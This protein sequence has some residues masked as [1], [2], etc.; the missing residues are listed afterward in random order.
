[1][2]ITRALAFVLLASSCSFDT[3]LP[4]APQL[5]RL[6]G[7][8][9]TQGHL[10]AEGQTVTLSSE[11]GDRTT[12]TT[13]ANGRFGFGDL[14]PGL[15]L[16]SAALPG[17]ARTSS[18]LLRVRAGQDTDA[19]VLRPDWLQNSPSE[20]T[21]SGKVTANGGGD[22][23]GAKIE[24]VLAGVAIAQV[25]VAGDGAFVQRL[26]PGT[27]TLR[28]SHPA[29]VTAML[30]DV[31][32][33]A[34][35]QRDL[36]A[37]PLVL[38]INPATLSGVVFRERDGQAPVA[39]AGATMTLDT[40]QTT[41]VDP[42]GNFT[43][44]GLAAGARQVR[45]TLVGHHDVLPT[46]PVV[47]EPGKTSTLEKVTL[48]IDRGQVVGVVKV[49][50]N[51][52]VSGARVELQGTNLAALVS[53]DPSDP[54][55]GGFV[56][57]NVPVGT[58][59]L[60]ARKDQYSNASAQ[61]V[62]SSDAPKDVGT[63][64]LARLLGDFAIDD[65]DSAN[66][67]GYTRTRAVTLNFTGFPSTGVA[68]FRA[69]EDPGF[70]G[71]TFQPYTGRLQPF[72]LQ[73]GEGAHTVYA[74]YQDTQGQTS[75][76]FTSAIVLDTIAPAAPMVQFDATGVAGTTRYTSR[77]QDLPLQ[78]VANDGM[79]S[80][81][82]L[83]RVGESVD[84]QGQV[85]R[86][87][88]T[89]KQ[90]ATLNRAAPV[91]GLQ[92]G[93]VQVIDHAGN[94]SAA[95]QAQVVVD[96]VAPSG[97]LAIRRGAKATDDGYT[98]QALVTLDETFVDG[99]GG[100]VLVKLANSSAELNT[101]VFQPA[102]TTASWL[103]NAANDG[104]KSVFAGFRDVAG[105]EAMS[106]AQASI[107]YDTQAPQ[108]ASATVV[109]AAIRNTA[110]VTLNLVTNPAD[111]SSTQALTV[112]D[113]P[114]FT[115]ASSTTPAAFPGTSQVAFVLSAGDGP[116]SIF[117]RYRDRAGNDAITSAQVTLDTVAP[118]GS[119]T[120]V[121]AL[122][123]GTP[124][125]TVTATTLV[126]VNLSPGDA[127]E[128][129]LGDGTM[130][131]CPAAGYTALVGTTI[132]NHPLPASGVVRVCLRDA[133]GNTRLLP[134]QTLVLDSAAP[135]SCA[136]VVRGFR[137]DGTDAPAGRSARPAILVSATGC[138]G[139]EVPREWV[140]TQS[141]VTCSAPGL[142]WQP[143]S[144]EQPYVLVGGDATHT[145]R[146][147][148]RDAARNP[149]S[150]AAAT[151]D[152]DTTA[153]SGVSVSIDTGAAY[154]NAAQYAARGNV[155][156]AQVAGSATGAT[157]WALSTTTTFGTYQAFPGTS[158]Q[159]FTFLGTGVQRVF[160]SF[161]DDLGNTAATVVDDI[162]FDVTAPSVAGSTVALVTAAPDPAFI[163]SSSVAARVAP[164]VPA[165]AAN[166]YLAQVSP[167][168]ACSAAAFGAGAPATAD[169]FFIANGG[170]G[171]KRLCVAYDDAAGNFSSPLTLDFTV[172]TTPPGQP[173][174][175]TPSQLTN[176]ADG[177]SFNVV[178][179]G[180]VVESNFLRYERATGLA[181]SW[182]TAS[183]TQS[184][185]SFAFTVASSAAVASTANVFKL[186]AVDRAGNTSPSSEVVVTTDVV[187]PAV[188]TL[189]QLGVQNFD[190]RGRV[191]WSQVS[192]AVSYRVHYGLNLLP[193]DG[194]YADQGASGFTVAGGTGM[195]E[196]SSLPNGAITYVTVQAVDAAGNRSAA[197]LNAG[198]TPVNVVGVQP[199]VI[200]PSKVNEVAVPGVQEV[201]KI[202]TQ[203][204][205]G[206]FGGSSLGCATV[207]G[208]QITMTIGALDL[209]TLSS[210]VQTGALVLPATPPS[211]LWSFTLADG[212]TRSDCLNTGGFDLLVDGPHLFVISNTRLRIYRIVGRAQAP[213]LL[214]TITF[215]SMAHKMVAK[216]N[217]LFVVG[218]FG[219]MALDMNKLVDGVAGVPTLADAL[220]P[221]GG[222]LLPANAGSMVLSRNHLLVTPYNSNATTV[223]NIADAIDS[224]VATVWDGNDVTFPQFSGTYGGT[225]YGARAVSGNAVY[226]TLDQPPATTLALRALNTV[227]SGVANGNNPP[228]LIASA[229]GGGDNVIV[230]NGAEV[231][232]SNKSSPYLFMNDLSS[233]ALGQ[234]D[235]GSRTQLLSV[236]AAT[237]RLV[238]AEASYGPYLLVGTDQGVIEV[239]ESATPSRLR[240]VS[241]AGSGGPEM[242]VD[243][244]FLFGSTF[245]V[246]DLHSGFPPKE[247]VPQAQAYGFCSYFDLVRVGESTVHANAF[248]GGYLTVIDQGPATDRDPATNLTFTSPPTPA[249]PSHGYNVSLGVAGMTVLAVEAWGNSLVAVELRTDGLYLEVF[250]LTPVRNGVGTMNAGASR[251]SIRLSTSLYINPYV[252]LTLSHGRA[253]VSY[254]N[255][256]P[257]FNNQGRPTPG[258]YAV[259]FRNLVDDD[260]LTVGFVLQGSLP[261]AGAR[262]V[263]LRGNTAFITRVS[264]LEAWDVGPAMDESAGTVLSATMPL[265]SLTLAPDEIDG[266]KVYGGYAFVVNNRLTVDGRLWALDVS[267]PG[268]MRI[269]S[270]VNEAW[271]HPGCGGGVRSGLAFAGSRLY[272]SG[273]DSTSVLEVE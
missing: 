108:P 164:G 133:A 105:N 270:S 123:D 171:A 51:A 198:D 122:A 244:A 256:S 82:S 175:L 144:A 215:A 26:P 42:A 162:T 149:G 177:T 174:L 178:T 74:Q 193:F 38:D 157:Q 115:S 93:Y 90:G 109:G 69:S 180:A 45:F 262:E 50:D 130:T 104:P 241:R 121:G 247:Q 30:A 167:A 163:A 125:S 36:S 77:A 165:G 57:Q 237:Q 20:A 204:D 222:G 168:V 81:L 172:D 2:K 97:T 196:L 226:L 37:M 48:L 79:G 110:S 166:V 246:L 100:T 136:L 8:L 117:V 46:R 24:F 169:L 140:L 137:V 28:A 173:S 266:L 72:T 250:D 73:V 60:V 12:A 87:T 40:G 239:Y 59:S 194:T 56:I 190:G 13:E 102:A 78:V 230:L 132:S 260:P 68:S 10:P 120:L 134:A 131:S 155:L 181:P 238:R 264:T 253:F 61:V 11:A 22:V 7:T 75:Q 224:N 234:A 210:P 159:S 66:T 98:N 220:G 62:V 89:Y 53:A 153:P 252:D 103:L 258:V 35:E 254:E 138:A 217:F 9:D 84:G 207:S 147:C 188:P 255:L 65:A 119:F 209:G 31:V 34:A 3:E 135:A 240:I 211:L 43:L 192:D 223:I 126:T 269:L 39:A 218:A 41:T 4:E 212:L 111:L 143:Y 170:D 6:V 113:E 17:F 156:S 271:P 221:I 248:S 158:P 200:S 64:T 33:G 272:A 116:R 265:G 52:P 92:R 216:G 160:A 5:G 233:A 141:A 152:L 55:L 154:V 257:Q 27:F 112:S 21:L 107:T 86:P 142:A 80:G 19:G 18:E 70:D 268:A 91:D 232:T 139:G 229:S 208:A 219:T 63:L 201:L 114:T 225:A 191:F 29:F 161:R 124:S 23:T 267:N 128:Y 76:A 95:G 273:R 145:L 176:L 129:R 54:S 185:S 261:V 202:Q 205:V 1:M 197:T 150:A 101:A 25:T 263:Q 94:A 236:G 245:N 44:T 228:P 186:R 88:E 242:V 32:L 148:V 231:Y 49:A 199:N 182:V 118:T 106:P 96:T 179:T 195:V 227:W 85:N 99:D 249:L 235:L 67:A 16:V 47:L 251:G 184:T 83:M 214:T 203:G 71:G 206:Y 187:P 183:T 146:G 58:Y 151:I 189:S 127:T 15:Y 243:G 259:D 213:T 14:R